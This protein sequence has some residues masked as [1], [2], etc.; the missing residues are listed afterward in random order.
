M[1][2]I[3]PAILP[4]VTP[5]IQSAT[6]TGAQFGIQLGSQRDTGRKGAY[7]P[8][9][10]NSAEATAIDDVED[11][12]SRELAFYNQVRLE[13]VLWAC[14]PS[15]STSQQQACRFNPQQ[16]MQRQGSDP[17]SYETSRTGAQS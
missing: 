7:Q 5:N 8:Q 6:P 11:D 14:V 15:A 12:L 4:S 9:A 16:H 13:R 10:I 1:R 2:L 3:V 17:K